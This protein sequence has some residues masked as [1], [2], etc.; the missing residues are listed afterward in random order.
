[1]S[2][3]RIDR[4]GLLS[5]AALLLMA[6]F[7]SPVM[8]AAPG[9]DTD[10]ASYRHPLETQALGD[11]NGALQALP[12]K[13]AEARQKRAWQALASLYLAKANACRVI[14]DWTCQRDAGTGAFEA[15]KQARIPLLQVRGLIADARARVALQDYSHGEQSLGQAQL[16]L[17]ATPSLDLSADVVLAYSSLSYSLGR[18]EQAVRYADRGLK[19]LPADEALPTQVRLLRN[20]ARAQAYLRQ[21]DEAYASLDRAESLMAQVNDPKLH[22]ELLI[23]RARLAHAQRDTATQETAGRQVLAL[24]R[25]LRNAQL[26]GQGREVI[27]L[28]AVQAGKRVEGER[29]LQSAVELFRQLG[30]GRE[31]LRVL[32]ELIRIGAESGEPSSAQRALWLRYLD[33]QSEIERSDRA[34]ASDD[35]DARVE[36]AR[37]SSDVQQLQMKADHAQQQANSL[38]RINRLNS[39]LH[40]AG[41]AAFLTVAAFYLLKRGSN[42]RLAAALAKQRESEARYRMLADHSSDI[43]VR[44]RADGHRLYVSPAAKAML[45]WEP[46]ELSEPRWELVH[47]DDRAPLADTVKGLFADGG[48]VQTAYRARHKD[49]HYVWIEALARRVPAEGA[50]GGYEVVYTGRDISARKRAE[51]DLA[52][53]RQLLR[54]VTDNMPALIAYIDTEERYRF[55]NAMYQKVFGV[56]P[57]RMI[58]RTLEEVRGGQYYKDI[59][60]HVMAALAGRRTTFEGQ[61]EV[62]GQNYHYQS[63][64]LP[65]LDE[66]GKV[67]GFFALTLDITAL[68]VAEIELAQQAR[69]DSLTGLANRRHF[70]ERLVIALARSKR[71]HLPVILM[72]LDIDHFKKINDNLGH[73]VGDQVIREFARRLAGCVREEDLVARFGG[74]EFVV[75]VEDALSPD[76]AEL[77]ASKLIDAM[78]KPIVLEEGEVQATSSIGIAFYWQTPMPQALL[79]AADQ[80]LYAAKAAGRNTFRLVERD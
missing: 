56:P 74:D 10:W 44:M 26:E 63:N 45:G 2:F 12:A 60:P 36:Y 33:L 53:S 46:S 69:F 4:A 21:P 31:E 30:Q 58:G 40:L 20:R 18:H 9:P 38:S 19:M 37:R 16:L 39:Y 79:E 34:K 23:E 68:K 47:P 43:V 13:I 78:K 8:A 49:G 6:F 66:N 51:E 76:I 5:V 61:G 29:E 1:M 75:L 62:G 77:I 11:P 3:R 41:F 72:Y 54:A 35:F 48:T 52:R 15:A 71:Q 24:A 80:A 57:E 65:D 7:M 32:Q 70:D 55:A 14:A 17:Q 50:D 28:A 64:Y 73:G 59:R 27:G 42:K 22:A 25:Q 67:R